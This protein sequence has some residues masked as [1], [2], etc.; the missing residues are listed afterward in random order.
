M[1]KREKVYLAQ[2]TLPNIYRIGPV[3]FIPGLNY[4]T[5]SQWEAIKDHPHL[6]YRFKEGHI[7]WV[8][9]KGPEDYVESR[10]ETKADPVS[11]AGD[12]EPNADENMEQAADVLK[13]LNT[14]ESVKLV[15]ETL[16]LALLEKWKSKEDRSG[17]KKAIEDQIAAIEAMS[18]EEG[19]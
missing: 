12:Q 17:V 10:K 5:E 13:S 6:P 14:K 1:Q 3:R 15:K 11:D 2:Y 4:V 16:D 7:K 19:K 8:A 18:S 9:N